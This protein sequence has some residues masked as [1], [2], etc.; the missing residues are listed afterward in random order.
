MKIPLQD[1]RKEKTTTG[2]LFELQLKTFLQHAWAIATH[3]L[4]YKGEDSNWGSSRIAYQIK[5]ILENAEISIMESEKLALSPLV[6]MSNDH[7]ERRKSIIEYLENK[8]SETSLP[9][10][11][12][13]LVDNLNS[14][15]CLTY[16]EFKVISDCCDSSLLFTPKPPSNISPFASIVLALLENNSLS[17]KIIQ[18]LRKNKR[19]LFIPREA[20]ELLSPSKQAL[21]KDI[22]FMAE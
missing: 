22:I 15:M 20:H 18:K 9:K 7:F 1:G 21:V 6:Q 16:L 13:G 11:I 19:K 4:I 17:S 2:V 10:N 3:D 14:L 8:W 5:A 12:L